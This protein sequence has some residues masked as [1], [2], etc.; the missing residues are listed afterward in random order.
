[1][2]QFVSFIGGVALQERDAFAVSY[3][4]LTT[5]ALTRSFMQTLVSC[6]CQLILL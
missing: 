3:L 1:M 4:V 2:G 5:L 6:S